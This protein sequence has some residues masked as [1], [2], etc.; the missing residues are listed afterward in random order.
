MRALL[1]RASL[2]IGMDSGPLHVADGACPAIG[3]FTIADP[4][5]R[6]SKAVTP[7]VA[8]VPCVGCL[9]RQ[10]PPLTDFDCEYPTGDKLK[11]CCLNA[12]SVDDVLEKA[13]RIVRLKK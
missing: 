1:E 8:A 6:V 11:H 10:K 3:I 7:V 13:M 12:V 4:D 9:H 5:K 2:F